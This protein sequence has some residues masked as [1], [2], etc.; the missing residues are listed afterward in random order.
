MQT[1]LECTI[2]MGFR[3]INHKMQQASQT[4]NAMDRLCGRRLPEV[5]K[6]LNL[7]LSDAGNPGAMKSL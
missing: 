4:R 6:T 1:I 3:A 7:K 5:C 2:S